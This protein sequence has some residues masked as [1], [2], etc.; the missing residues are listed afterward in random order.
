M[1]ATKS[2]RIG[3]III[4]IVMTVGTIGSFFIMIVANN[5]SQQEQQQLADQQQELYEQQQKQA[6]E[7]Q[8]EQNE[9]AEKLSPT[10]YPVFE[11]YESNP[12]PFDASK[13]KKLT[14]KDLVKGDGAEVES[15]SDLNIYYIGWDASGEEFDS[16][17]SGEKLSAPLD[18]SMGVIDGM[19][20]GIT[21]M[22]IGGVREITMT[23]DQAYGEDAPE[24]YPSGPL[25]FI[26]LAIPPQN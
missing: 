4:A 20:E 15:A 5:N 24:G 1:S 23:A 16:S 18:P 26:V 7:F 19:S 9:L 6:E 13:V 8:K 22:K 10:Y 3:I 12:A 2:Q 11:E 17:F 14:T 21:G 25:K